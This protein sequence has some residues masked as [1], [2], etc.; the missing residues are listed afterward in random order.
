MTLYSGNWTITGAAGAQ[1][2]SAPL[3]PAIA[4]PVDSD[5]AAHFVYVRND[6]PTYSVWVGNPASAGGSFHNA[7]VEIRPGGEFNIR[8]N[9]AQLWVQAD[10][11]TSP[12]I[13]YTASTED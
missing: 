7:M 8:L 13:A 9:R 10:S 11:G 1:S 12:T 6:D 2:L 4:T 3:L 5:F